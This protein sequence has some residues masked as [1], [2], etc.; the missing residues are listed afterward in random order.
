M[1]ISDKVGLVSTVGK[2]AGSIAWERWGPSPSLDT[3]ATVPPSAEAI[4]PQWLTLA[5]CSKVAGA[6]VV[7][8]SVEG[9]HDGT[10]ARRALDVQYNEAGTSAGLPTKL[11]TKL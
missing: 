7:D 1:S 6:Q 8:V 11:F 3:A 10:S 9:G 4:T 5:V 2:I